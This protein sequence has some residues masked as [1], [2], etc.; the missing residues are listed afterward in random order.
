MTALPPG[1]WEVK[2]AGREG[3]VDI[4][5]P[6]D[7]IVALVDVRLA[8]DARLI[9]AAPEMFDLLNDPATNTADWAARRLALL[10]RVAGDLTKAVTP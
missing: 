6:R 3:W 4:V 9:A 7:R 5:D 10:L 8:A 2:G 1:P